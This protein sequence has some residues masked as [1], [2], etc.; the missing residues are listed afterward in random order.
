MQTATTNTMT[1]Y[2]RT[3]TANISVHTKHRTPYV[4]AI[5]FIQAHGHFAAITKDGLLAMS[6]YKLPEPELETWLGTKVFHVTEECN[7][8]SDCWAELPTVFEVDSDGMVCSRD[9]REWLGY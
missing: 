8:F 9:V 4:V 6:V 7:S 3:I 5:A 2:G 1:D